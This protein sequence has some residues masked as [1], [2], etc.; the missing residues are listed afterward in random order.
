MNYVEATNQPH[1]DA[2]RPYVFVAGGITDCPDWQTELRS[3]LEDLDFTLL[4][5]RRA[6]FPIDDPKAAREQISW[7]HEWL[8]KS[9]IISFW[10]CANTLNPIVLYELGSH[11]SRA[12]SGLPVEIIVG[13]EPGYERT[14]DVMIQTELTKLPVMVVYDLNV[15]ASVLRGMI[16]KMK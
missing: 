6:D 1:P 5:P 10:F 11:L 12:S 13:I 8:W 4:N 15:L 16:M 14:Q 7:E 9:D 3:L 2:P